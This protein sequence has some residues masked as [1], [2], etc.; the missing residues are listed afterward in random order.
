LEAKITEEL[1]KAELDKYNSLNKLSQDD[2][3]KVEVK[4]EETKK[5]VEEPKMKISEPI[6]KEAEK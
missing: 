1:E 2:A 3:K 6:K 4:V 5:K